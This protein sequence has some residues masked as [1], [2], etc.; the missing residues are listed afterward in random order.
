MDFKQWLDKN[1][2][3]QDDAIRRGK[4]H[5]FGWHLFEKKYP[6]LKKDFP[7]LIFIWEEDKD[8]LMVFSMVALD[9]MDKVELEQLA[10]KYFTK[11]KSTYSRSGEKSVH[12]K[13]ISVDHDDEVNVVSPTPENLGDME[14][15]LGPHDGRGVANVMMSI[16]NFEKQPINK[17]YNMIKYFDE[18]SHKLSR[19]IAM[20]TPFG[21]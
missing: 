14:V 5:E 3:V 10:Q 15:S 8:W 18:Q 20:D 16:R 11:F 19:K 17:V 12:V 13:H 7:N 2:D 6:Q 21:V 1:S 9:E 4:Q